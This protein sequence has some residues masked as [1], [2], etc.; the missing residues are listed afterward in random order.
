MLLNALL[1]IYDRGVIHQLC[2][3]L[4]LVHKK[5]P[6]ASIPSDALGLLEWATQMLEDHQ[7]GNQVQ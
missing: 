1:S 6:G 3:V 5:D 4:V 7:L 2:R